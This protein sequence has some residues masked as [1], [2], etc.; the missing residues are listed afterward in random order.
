MPHPP[1]RIALMMSLMS[2]EHEEDSPTQ[3]FQTKV[4]H[5]AFYGHLVNKSVFA[6]KSID[7]DYLDKYASDAKFQHI[8]LFKFIQFSCD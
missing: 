5:D 3:Q 6:H 8:G 2:Y 7:W 1:E 4:H